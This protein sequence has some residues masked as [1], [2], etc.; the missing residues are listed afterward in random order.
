MNLKISIM[1]LNWNG[2]KYLKDCFT[3]LEN[4]T[5]SN[6]E[7]VLIDNGS[8]DGS[9]EY[10]KSNFPEVKI[11]ALG[12]NLGFAEGNNK[13][14]KSAKGKYVFILN[15]DTKVD[16][17]CLEKLVEVAE[18]DDRTGMWAPQR[19]FLLKTPT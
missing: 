14:I 8:K 9:L 10:V 1:V 7:I 17:N 16:K 19:R 13:G 6:F 2:K 11:L 5:Y 4:Q 12:K 3:S 15:N 18:S